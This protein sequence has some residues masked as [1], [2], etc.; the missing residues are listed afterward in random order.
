M[1]FLRRRVHFWKITVPL[2]YWMIQY[3]FVNLAG[4][5]VTQPAGID[6]AYVL[7]L[8]GLDDYRIIHARDISVTSRTGKSLHYT[9]F[10][11]DRRPVGAT[12]STTAG[13]WPGLGA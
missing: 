8:E 10:T 7:K 9:Q 5:T 11:C 12:A 2:P 3:Q 4:M 13:A 6:V 1:R